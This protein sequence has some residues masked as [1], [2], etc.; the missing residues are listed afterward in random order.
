MLV[1]APTNEA[2]DSI[3]ERVRSMASQFDAMHPRAIVRLWS[4]A[5]VKAQYA[6]R[7]KTLIQSSFHIESLRRRLAT[8]GQGS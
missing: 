1:S 8:G 6:G 5:Q 3:L 2:V 4:P 7:E